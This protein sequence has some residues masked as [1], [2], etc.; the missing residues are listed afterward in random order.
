METIYET[1]VTEKGSNMDE[2][3]SEKIIILFKDDAPEELRNYCVLHNK[4]MLKEEIK[5]GY[6]LEINDKSYKITAVGELVNKNLAELGHISI[7]FTGK[8]I[9]ELPG[10]LYVEGNELPEI[11]KGDVIRIKK[12]VDKK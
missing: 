11:K 7:C 10:S 2:L 9:A 8:E 1:E 3:R 12:D 4:N 5:T 6:T